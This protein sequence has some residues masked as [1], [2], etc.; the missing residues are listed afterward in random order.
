MNGGNVY[1]LVG[2]SFDKTHLLDKLRGQTFGPLLL[3][4]LSFLLPTVSPSLFI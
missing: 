2:V 4:W 1:H 3:T